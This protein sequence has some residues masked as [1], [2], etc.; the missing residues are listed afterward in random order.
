MYIQLQRYYSQLSASAMSSISPDFRVEDLPPTAYYI[1]DFLSQ[2][3]EEQIMRQIYRTPTVRWTQLRNRRLIN[4][5]GVPHPRGMIAEPLPSWLQVW[6]FRSSEEK[7]LTI[8]VQAFWRLVGMNSPK[9][10]NGSISLLVPF[11]LD[12][13]I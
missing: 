3:R 4:F 1:P 6:V 7:L 13:T 9:L 5:G 10:L 12:R 8:R 2:E 11:F